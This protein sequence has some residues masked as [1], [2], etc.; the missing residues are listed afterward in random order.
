MLSLSEAAL[1]CGYD[2]RAA[3][4]RTIPRLLEFE[5]RRGGAEVEAGLEQMLAPSVPG[6]VASGTMPCPSKAAAM[7][8][9]VVTDVWPPVSH[10]TEADSGAR[11]AADADVTPAAPA[12][13]PAIIATAATRLNTRMSTPFRPRSVAAL[14]L[15]YGAVGPARCSRPE[16]DTQLRFS[17]RRRTRRR[18]RRRPRATSRVPRWTSSAGCSR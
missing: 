4:A 13:R 6:R 1:R 12:I 17:L 9:A 15:T 10:T 5:Q 18:R 11:V 3:V 2:D 7:P 16:G 14:L 8:G